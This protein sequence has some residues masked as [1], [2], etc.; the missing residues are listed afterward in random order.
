MTKV[1]RMRRDSIQQTQILYNI[2]VRQY[3]YLLHQACTR[4]SL[5]APQ[6]FLALPR[7]HPYCGRVDKPLT[8]HTPPRSG[9]AAF[10]HPAPCK[11][12]Y[13]TII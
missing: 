13:S 5:S 1:T 9:R 7:Q 10:P 12:Y 3:L 6:Q 4:H 8:R 11:A 2:L